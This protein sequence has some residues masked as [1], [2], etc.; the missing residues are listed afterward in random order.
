MTLLEAHKGAQAVIEGTLIDITTRKQAEQEMSRAMEAAESAS[1][2]KSEF[3]ANMS[4]EIR[5]PL[6]GVIGMTDLVLDSELTADQSLEGVRPAA[7][8][9]EIASPEPGAVDR[10]QG[11]GER[12]E[13]EV[14]KSND[15]RRSVFSMS[16]ATATRLSFVGVSSVGPSKDR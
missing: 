10:H 16:F 9:K 2:A 14:L 5:T 7:D 1:R 3:L 12:I 6:N 15:V 11:A 4:H 8:A 13:G